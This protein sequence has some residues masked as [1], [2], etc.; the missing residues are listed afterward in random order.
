MTTITLDQQPRRPTRPTPWSSASPAGP[1]G[2]VLAPGARGGRRRARRQ[3]SRPRVAALGATGQG[4]RGHQAAAPRRGRPRRSWSP[5]GSARPRAGRRRATYDREV[6]RRAAGAATRALAG[7]ASV[8]ARAARRTTPRTPRGRRGRAARRL[9]L[10]PLP[11]HGAERQAGR[12]RSFALLSGSAGDEAAKAGVEPRRDRRRG[13]HLARDLVNTPPPTCTRPTFADEAD[14]AA[15]AAGVEIEVLDEKELAKGGYGGIL[16][17][18]QGSAHPPR[19]VKITYSP[20]AADATSRWSARASRSTPAACRSSRPTAWTD[21]E[22]RHGRRRRGRR[23]DH[24]D[25]RAR[26]AGQ[27]RRRTPPW[28]RTCRPA[29]RSRPSDVLTMYGGKTVEV[30]N[31]DAEG[32]LVLADAHRPGQRGL[33]RPDRRRRDAHRR[34]ARRAR[35]PDHGVMAQRRRPPRPRSPA[36]AG[37]PA[38]RC[39]RCRCRPSCATASTRG[40]RPRQH[41]R[42]A[43]AACSPPGCSCKEFV[44]EGS[45]GRTSTSPARRLDEAVRLHA[46][47]RHR[48]AVRTLVASPRTSPP[49]DSSRLT[50]RTLGRR[51]ADSSRRP[52][53][54]LVAHAL[55][56][57]D[58]RGV[59]RRDAEL[60]ARARARPRRVGT[61]RRVHSPSSRDQ[62]HRGRR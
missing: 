14:A 48:V 33:P 52:S 8:G 7:S 53:G 26:A 59:V 17:V 2:L 27:R 50:A 12:S 47:G 46:E 56:V 5:S 1:D 43:G 25:R 19:L 62:H 3:R 54:V 29:P 10:R 39:G 23:R 22:V 28:P 36:A 24:R 41:R 55:R 15:K 35:Q 32:R 11:H 6:L 9:R 20:A 4:R 61:R 40:R 42:R 31:T 30:L 51:A 49:A 18:G 45:A 13:R 38:S 34:P 60:R 57:A 21:D 16:G 44:A 58:D 37:G